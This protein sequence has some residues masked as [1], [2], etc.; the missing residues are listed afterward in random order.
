MM[1]YPEGHKIYQGHLQALNEE[2]I[3]RLKSE[4]ETISH[5]PKYKE[6]AALAEI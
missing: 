5:E 3:E 6:M 4:I 2:E 1:L